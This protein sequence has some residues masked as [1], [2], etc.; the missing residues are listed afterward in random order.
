[1]KTATKL[2]V[3]S[4]MKSFNFNF[5]TQ[6][7]DRLYIL[8]DNI[9]NEEGQTIYPEGDEIQDFIDTLGE[10]FDEFNEIETDHSV[11]SHFGYQNCIIYGND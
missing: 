6:G 1:M 11:A 3:S 2:Q 7:S 5:E 10:N 9:S 8:W 4:K